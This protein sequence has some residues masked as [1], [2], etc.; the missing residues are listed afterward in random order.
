MT[1]PAPA[2]T[3]AALVSEPLDNDDEPEPPLGASSTEP[4]PSTESI[5]PVMAGGQEET[6][7]DLRMAGLPGSSIAA[8]VGPGGFKLLIIL[9]S[10]V[11]VMIESS[12]LVD[13]LKRAQ[14]EVTISASVDGVEQNV[15]IS[16]TDFDEPVSHELAVALLECRSAG[17]LSDLVVELLEAGLSA[18]PDNANYGVAVSTVSFILTLAYVLAAK[19]KPGTLS[20]FALPLPRNQGTLSAQQLFYGFLL[21]W[22]GPGACVLTFHGPYRTT[23]N[24]YFACWAALFSSA[25]LCADAFTKMKVGL[26]TIKGAS[27]AGSHLREMAGLFVSSVTLFFASVDFGDHS[28][29]KYGISLGVISTAASL[30]TPYLIDT[31][32]IGPPVRKIIAAFLFVLWVA[33]VTVLTFDSPFTA[34]GNGYFACWGGTVCATLFAYRE[35]FEMQVQWIDGRFQSF[36]CRPQ[37]MPGATEGTAP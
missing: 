1:A 16:N 10:S 5:D 34:T 32:K 15:T 11:I 4:R 22:W 28:T 25:M 7:S 13:K 24:P 19:Y 30:A 35:F 31:K 20:N 2:E 26:Q 3:P 12:I 17:T 8:S 18:T 14:N 37:E 36:S 9:I 29:G 23:S 33:A 6:A 27:E 21:L